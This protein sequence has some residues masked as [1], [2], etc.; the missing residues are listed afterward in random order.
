MCFTALCLLLPLALVIHRLNMLFFAEAWL[1]IF[2]SLRVLSAVTAASTCV[3]IDNTPTEAGNR[4]L[5]PCYPNAP[6]SPC[7]FEGDSCLSGGACYGGGGLSYRGACTGASNYG[8]SQCL[9]HCTAGDC[10]KAILVSDQSLQRAK[11]LTIG[12]ALPHDS[13]NYFP[14]GNSSI[15]PTSW[16]E[17]FWFARGESFINIRNTGGA[18]KARSVKM[19]TMV[20]RCWTTSTLALCQ[21]RRS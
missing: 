15:G 20:V 3:W 9:A 18:E 14:C 5:L 21:S 19:L 10:K 6:I 16:Y 12:I 17:F 11:I 4:T 13:A 2:F 8:S 1:R 7:C